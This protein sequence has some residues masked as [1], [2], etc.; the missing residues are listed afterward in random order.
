[1]RIERHIGKLL[2]LLALL[3]GACSSR[4]A[5]Q[6]STAEPGA[7]PT[8][9]PH[10]EGRIAYL[11]AIGNIHTIHPDGTGHLALT[12]DAGPI[13]DSE[14]VR[15]YGAFAWSQVSDRLAFTEQIEAVSGKG[16][17]LL[18]V[19]TGGGEQRREVFDRAGSTPFYL[20]WAGAREALTFLA[21]RIGQTELDLWMWEAGDLQLLDRGQPYYWAWSPAD[22][23]I[24]TH[25]GGGG[26]GGRVGRLVGPGETV[27]ASPVR[28][29]SFQAPAF[30][31]DGSQFVVAGE[32][33]DAR[34]LLLVNSA[35][36]YQG[37]LAAVR[38]GVAFDWSPAGDRL[39]YVE[40]RSDRPA[41]FGELV[42]LSQVSDLAPQVRRTGVEPVA[43]FFWSPSGERLA[44][45]V[46]VEGPA[47]GQQQVSRRVQGQ[48]LRL[49][50]V[51]IDAV[52]GDSR[53]VTEFLPTP[54]F[55]A[56]LPFYDQYQRSSTIWSP[57][58]LALVFTGRRSDGFGG[59]F[60]LEPEGEHPLL[61]LIGR[62]ELA[63][64][65]FVDG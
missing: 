22:N 61:Q 64:W 8:A 65:S 6:R 2:C 5:T 18:H 45:F 9:A 10:L 48:E 33:E 37:E 49:Q 27:A 17:T 23:L 42:L 36:Q 3:A 55:L 16:R 39:A 21:S 12:E 20:Y 50:I 40:Q 19:A 11:D 30:A 24:V 35:G 52:S 41:G 7:P 63:F 47:G 25:V 53:V 60:V 43:A 4:P 1:M 31:P 28:P 58:G 34:G 38:R 51:L 32:L 56:I 14:G 62:G 26:S 57:D 15:R 59:V 44:A 54:A 13:G 29:G 46:P